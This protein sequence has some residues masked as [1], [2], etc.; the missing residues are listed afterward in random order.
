MNGTAMFFVFECYS[1][2]TFLFRSMSGQVAK[3]HPVPYKNPELRRRQLH[4]ETE[5][6]LSYHFIACGLRRVDAE[7]LLQRLSKS[8]LKRET[9][10][11]AETI[12][13]HPACEQKLPTPFSGRESLR[14]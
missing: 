3:R 9:Q 4:A 14:E 13:W 7:N 8:D 1:Q 6:P 11:D 10:D 2:G 12:Y 5:S